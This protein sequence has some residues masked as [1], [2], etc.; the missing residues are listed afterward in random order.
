M[1]V[2]CSVS[3]VTENH[4]RCSQKSCSRCVDRW[5]HD[6]GLAFSLKFT[7]LKL[8]TNLRSTDLCPM[9][10]I[11]KHP[12]FIMIVYQQTPN[13]TSSTLKGIQPRNFLQCVLFEIE[14]P[15][16]YGW[17]ELFETISEFDTATQ[18]SDFLVCDSCMCLWFLT[19]FS[20]CFETAQRYEL[21]AENTS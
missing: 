6:S 2:R 5:F 19:S 13:I 4:L 8:R 9:W 10:C 20:S 12:S 11:N 21:L 17:I 3:H 18:L 7:L 1:N 16:H 15:N 14:I